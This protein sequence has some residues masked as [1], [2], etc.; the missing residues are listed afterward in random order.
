MQAATKRRTTK[1]P[2]PGEGRDE[3]NLAEFPIALL[4][5]RAPRG[6]NTLEFQDVIRD[7]QVGEPVI[8]KLTVMGTSKLGLPTARDDE[9][10]LGL[11]QLTRL[12]NNFN[13]RNV[14]FS[15]YELLRL[16]GW[17]DEGKNY[18]RID[19]SLHRWASIYL[20]YE[21]AWWDNRAKSWVDQG[22]HVIT[23][24]NLYEREKSSRR[25]PEQTVFPFSC[26][27]WSEVFFRSFQD[28]YLKAL[29]LDFYLRLESPIAKRMYRFLDK[30]FYRRTRQEYE[31]KD[32]ALEHVG[33]SRVCHTGQIKEKLA[34]AIEEL[35]AR[36]FLEPLPAGERY[37]QV[38]RGEWKVVFVRKAAAA[39]EKP[40]KA[41]AHGLE[42]ELTDRG[43]TAATAAEL[44]AGTPADLITSKIEVFDWMTEKQ[45]KRLSQNPAGYLVASIRDDYAAPKGF[46]PRAERERKQQAAA[47]SK[48]K[49]QEDRAAK[50]RREEEEHAARQ[51]ER[52]HI[53]CYLNGLTPQEREALEEQALA[54]ADDAMRAAAREGGPIGSIARRTLVE[55]EVLRIAPL[56]PPPA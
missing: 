31:L 32:F 50:R 16:L 9:I 55:R 17:N 30:H 4:S 6:V 26:F 24:I 5:D 49:E 52:A 41:A 25:P 3:L 38:R 7:P 18:R 13:E 22:F 46:E 45:D 56:T 40:K 2:D 21:K 12:Q 34:P 53:E 14:H 19:E 8:R 36:G 11:I 27:T 33:L 35:E 42:K 39:E 48:R 37:L 44:V 29:D 47:A 54:H 20:R 10:L 43:V 28:G 1:R 23:D 15:R 51:A